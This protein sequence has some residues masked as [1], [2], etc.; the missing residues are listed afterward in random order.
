M[1]VEVNNKKGACIWGTE[2]DIIPRV[3]ERI[4]MWIDVWGKFKHLTITNVRWIWGE[5]GAR[6]VILET[7]E[8][9]TY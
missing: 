5:Y 6:K 2:L 3:G 4:H 8:D 7:K 9:D 1:Y